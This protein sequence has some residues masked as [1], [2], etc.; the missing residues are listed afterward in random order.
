MLFRSCCCKKYGLGRV[1]LG[2]DDLH[3][4]TSPFLVR[5]VHPPLYRQRLINKTHLLFTLVFYTSLL[6]LLS[7]S[8]LVLQR[9][10]RGEQTDLGQLIAAARPHG[11]LLGHV[12]FGTRK[13]PARLLAYRAS[14]RFS[15][16]FDVSCGASPLTLKVHGD[17]LV[18]EQQASLSWMDVEANL[19]VSVKGVVRSVY[20][21][22]PDRRKKDS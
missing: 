20:H 19:L 18:C 9:G 4:K 13:A 17:V 6:F 22:T 14:E 2:F 7:R 1:L 11:V 21:F 10:S 3:G 12:G 5:K 8:S 15:F 16:S